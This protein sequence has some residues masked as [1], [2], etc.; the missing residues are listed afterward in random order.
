MRQ[1]LR[2]DQVRHDLRYALTLLRRDRTF[3]L[4]AALALG[5]AATTSL[6]TVVNAVILRGL[7]LAD[8]DRLVLLIACVN[9]ANL[10]LA[11]SVRRSREVGIR[12]ALGA[13]RW[14][15]VQQLLVESVSIAD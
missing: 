6:I 12:V 14:R 7:P 5:I 3:T 13:N 8:S 1:V 10:L 15:I 4:V 11:R 9:V 2:V